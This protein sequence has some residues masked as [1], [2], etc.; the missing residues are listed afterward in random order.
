M[1]LAQIEDAQRSPLATA[2]EMRS[3]VDS[4]EVV[5]GTA[6]YAPCGPAEKGY[7]AGKSQVNE[8]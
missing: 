4:A 1:E 2:D 6:N 7:P 5:Q 8:G 3:S